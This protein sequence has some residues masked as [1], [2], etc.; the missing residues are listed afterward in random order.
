MIKHIVFTLHNGGVGIFT[1]T[2]EIFRNMQIGGIW[3]DRPHGYIDEQI[4]RQI[5]SGIAPD[6]AARFAKAVAFGGIS[7]WEVYDIIRERDTDR[8]GTGHVLLDTDDI[9]FDRWFRN[10]WRQGGNSGRIYIDLDWARLAHWD[11]L[12]VAT[13]EANK[14][15]TRALRPLPP[16]S[17]DHLRGPVEAARDTDELKRIWPEGLP[18]C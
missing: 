2:A 7:E 11:R 10:G 17:V 9:P 14:R 16:L 1:P 4:E 13:D 5:S 18:Q 12:V 8:H 15:R 6:H 3:S